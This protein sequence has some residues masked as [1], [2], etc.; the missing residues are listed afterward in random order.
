MPKRFIQLL[1]PSLGVIFC[2]A[3]CFGGYFLKKNKNGTKKTPPPIQI[4][5]PL[6]QYAPVEFNLPQKIK[7]LSPKQLKEHE[8]LYHG[9]VKKRNEITEK[10]RKTDLSSANNISYSAYRELKVAQTFAMNGDILHR[11]Y[12]ENLGEHNSAVGPLMLEL[13]NK[14]Y[15]SLEAFKED[16]FAAALSSRGWVLTAYAID[17]GLIENYVLD[18]HNQTV[19][20][21]TI[22]L[23]VFDV[24]EHAYMID[25]GINRRA[26]LDVF[27]QDID[28]NVVEE[29]IR[30]WVL[31]FKNV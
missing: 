1:I 16:L 3:F 8:Q 13:I 19:P 9:Y 10:L 12:F 15:G 4:A 17:D 26:Y 11:L 2:T 29:R 20:I 6:P 25:F 14:R 27:W 18:A 30:K 28:W 24:Y 23:L 5:A 31:I 7:G 22:P 21:L